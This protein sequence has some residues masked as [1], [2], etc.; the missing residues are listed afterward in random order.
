MLLLLLSAC[1]S[2]PLVIPYD[3]PR[4]PRPSAEIMKPIEPDFLCRTE[5]FLSG[6][7]IEQI[8]QSGSCSTASGT[9]TK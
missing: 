8:E 1:A 3:P 6:K 2:K 4:V 5:S 9:S 7:A